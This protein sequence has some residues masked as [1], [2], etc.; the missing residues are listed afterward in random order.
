MLLKYQQRSLPW[1]TLWYNYDQREVRYTVTW[2]CVSGAT[3]ACW[4]TSLWY[5]G[6]RNYI[7][8]PTLGGFFI[9]TS[10]SM[11]WMY[12]T[13]RWGWLF[14]FVVFLSFFVPSTC[15]SCRN[16]F[17]Y[18]NKCGYEGDE[19]RHP[20]GRKTCRLQCSVQLSAKITFRLDGRPRIFE[21]RASWQLLLC[22]FI[23]PAEPHDG[24]NNVSEYPNLLHV[25]PHPWYHHCHTGVTARFGLETQSVFGFQLD[26]MK[27]NPLLQSQFVSEFWD[28]RWNLLIHHTFKRGVC[29]PIC[30]LH[31]QHSLLPYFLHLVCFTSGSITLL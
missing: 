10:V 31:Y 5:Q 17:W 16:G 19:Q 4:Q 6:I 20:T 23:V 25:C 24:R 1:L 11:R 30:S 27:K 26:H 13:Q 2:S 3:I 18:Q 22:S 14:A 29:K 21:S 15:T 8:D 9:L 28:R 7:T 12:R